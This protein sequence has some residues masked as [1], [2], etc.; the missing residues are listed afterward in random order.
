MKTPLQFCIF[1]RRVPLYLRLALA[2]L[3]VWQCIEYFGSYNELWWIA[4]TTAWRITCSLLSVFVLWLQWSSKILLKRNFDFHP[5]WDGR[6]KKVIGGEFIIKVDLKKNRWKML[7]C[8]GENGVNWDDGEGKNR[9]KS[10]FKLKCF[11]VMVKLRWNWDKNRVKLGFN[12][13]DL[14]WG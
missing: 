4:F 11:I 14:C 5:Q 1:F 9:V 13:N 7:F 8:Q 10:R 6:V 12:K 2:R 3:D